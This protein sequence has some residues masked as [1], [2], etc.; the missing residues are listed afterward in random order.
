ME[1]AIIGIIIDCF[2]LSKLAAKVHTTKVLPRL[3]QAPFLNL[4][5]HVRLTSPRSFRDASATVC[6]PY[7]CV[8][9]M[10]FFATRKFLFN[11]LNFNVMSIKFKSVAKGQPGVAG[12]G[13]IKYY[14]SI[15]RKE[16]VTL[17]SFATDLADRSTLTRADIYAVLESFMEKFPTYLTNGRIIHFGALGSFYPS[18]SSQGEIDPAHVS[19]YSINKVKIQF[20][21]SK[22]LKSLVRT[23]EFKKVITENNGSEIVE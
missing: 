2:L 13:E 16:P 10:A 14:A 11:P 18:I 23:A 15:V 3:Q 1:N 19:E 8:E 21:P 5:C 9:L 20:R 4:T 22:R 7:R 12:G 6:T 17:H